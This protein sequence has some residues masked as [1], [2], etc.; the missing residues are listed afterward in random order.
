MPDDY[1]LFF[2]FFPVLNICELKALRIDGWGWSF[3][4]DI[5]DRREVWSGHVDMQRLSRWLRFDGAS[6]QVFKK[7]D[8]VCLCF[9]HVLPY[10]TQK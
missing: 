4:S 1:E 7:N 10:L 9:G 3:D 5:E 6:R 2:L 8:A